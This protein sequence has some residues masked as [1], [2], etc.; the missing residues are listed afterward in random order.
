VITAVAALSAVIV[1]SCGESETSFAEPTVVAGTFQYSRGLDDEVRDIPWQITVN[2]TDEGWCGS[3]LEFDGDVLHGGDSACV[4][5]GDDG[6]TDA[7]EMA[8][9]GERTFYVL[10]APGWSQRGLGA[11]AV[12]GAEPT[13]STS[14]SWGVAQEGPVVL[15]LSEGGA[16]DLVVDV[17][18]QGPGG[19]EAVVSTP[20]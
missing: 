10:Y 17:Q 5:A 20:S 11:R 1:A 9:V 18:L 14:G 2:S 13:Q 12:E 16:Q 3:N 19:A 8:R 7:V 4:K 6:V 15:V